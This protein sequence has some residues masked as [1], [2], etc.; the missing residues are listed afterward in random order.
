ML[1]ALYTMSPQGSI[2][3]IG[4]PLLMLLCASCLLVNAEFYSS[5]DKVQELEQVE[6]DLV[7]ATRL[8]LEDQQLQLNVFQR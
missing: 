8:F 6:K 5:A 3:C 2:R 1:L 4:F 7:S